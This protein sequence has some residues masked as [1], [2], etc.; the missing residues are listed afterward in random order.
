MSEASQSMV[1]SADE[2]S[3][4]RRHL[5][6]SSGILLGEGKEYLVVSR[7]RRLMSQRNLPTITELLY[8]MDRDRQLA[9]QVV[10]AMTT[11]ETLW[12]RDS[13]PYQIFRERILPE[14]AAKSGQ[15]RIWSAA[16]STG[17]EPYS[18]KIE[19]AEFQRKYPGKLKSGI[20]ILAT[21]IS[22]SALTNA[23]QG[24]YP[25]LAIRRGMSE[26][27]LARYFQREGEDCWRIRTEMKSGIEFREFNLQSSYSSLGKFD[28]IFC[29][30]VLIYFSNERKRDILIRM[31][32]L[33]PPG[34]YLLLGASEAMTQLGEYYE[35]VA[36]HPGIMYC[37][38]AR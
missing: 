14:L 33:L 24:A 11:N 13:H 12:F 34:G 9:S 31:H 37:A 5:E 2:Y 29:R 28:V 25:W 10:D 3:Q 20:K 30:N 26:E 22:T 23:R 17:Q 19:E 6:T 21:D 8:C 15:L 4:F 36:C 7:L 35:M 38:K 18:L 32:A 27:H 16:C 1:V